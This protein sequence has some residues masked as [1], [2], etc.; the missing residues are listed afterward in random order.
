MG[1]GF[2]PL[3]VSPRRQLPQWHAECG[4]Q[5]P[6]GAAAP[7]PT[8]ALLSPCRPPCQAASDI[9]SPVSGEIVEANSDLG[10]DSAKVGVGGCGEG[11]HTAAAL[12]VP[13]GAGA[14]ACSA[15]AARVATLP[16][17]LPPLLLLLLLRP[18]SLPSH[19]PPRLSPHL[20]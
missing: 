19:P 9:Y 12:R 6:L 2:G 13:G 17:L 20:P 16:P 11:E 10:N 5:R 3:H 15:R 14:G 8:P 4:R 7:R 18:A 1:V